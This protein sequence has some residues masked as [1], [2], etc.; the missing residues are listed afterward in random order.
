[1]EGT[2]NFSPTRHS[3]LSKDDLVLITW[4]DDRFRLVD[5]R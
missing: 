2:F 3:G 5:Y 4:K 1:V